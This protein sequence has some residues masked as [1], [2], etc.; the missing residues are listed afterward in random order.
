MSRR[1]QRDGRRARVGYR[2]QLKR[3]RDERENGRAGQV[4]DAIDGQREDSGHG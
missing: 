2:L 3:R 1:Y 4:H